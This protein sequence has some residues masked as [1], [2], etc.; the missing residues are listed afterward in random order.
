MLNHIF[1]A[2]GIISAALFASLVLL[3]AVWPFFTAQRLNA[4][5]VFH[6]FLSYI[7]NVEFEAEEKIGR[8][9]S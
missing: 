9:T 5:S 7:T 2:W 1:E 8:R 4:K 6:R 3:L